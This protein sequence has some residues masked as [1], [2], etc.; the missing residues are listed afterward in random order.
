[1]K[2][3]SI[4]Y[5][6]FQQ[7]PRSFFELL[8]LPLT[9]ADQYQFTNLEVKQLAFRLDGL[10]FPSTDNPSQPFYLTEVQFQPDDDLY[11]RIFAEL[12]LYLRQYQ[13]PYPWRVVVIYPNRNTEREKS[14]HFSQILNSEAVTRIYLD[15]LEGENGLGVGIIKLVV[16]SESVAIESAQQLIEQAQ[17]ILPPAPLRRDIIDLIETIVVYKLP[18]ASREEIARMLGLTDLKQTRFYQEAFTEG[19]QE[20]RL[21]GL[22]EGLQEGR[23]E[24]LQE[25]RE[26]ITRN[27]VLRLNNLGYASEAIAEILG[28]PVDEILPILE[29]S[30]KG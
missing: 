9:E 4:F 27:I 8:N 2:T 7:Y 18:Q 20:G 16:A 26:E 28:L 22:Q 15:E 3:D 10:F 17:Q 11:Y 23:Q 30:N 14:Q 5:R 25:G 21:E 12:F 29:D 24:G 6:I 19:L 13:P 1:M